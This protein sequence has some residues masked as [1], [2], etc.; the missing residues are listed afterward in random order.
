MYGTTRTTLPATHSNLLEVA[1]SPTYRVN[2]SAVEAVSNHI[3]TSLSNSH[4]TKMVERVL[5][6]AF[7]YADKCERLENALNEWE[8]GKRKNF[9]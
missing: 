4:M 8:S 7:E 6:L 1:L 3:D 9:S 5:S 2:Q